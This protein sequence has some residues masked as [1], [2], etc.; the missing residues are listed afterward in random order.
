MWLLIGIIGMLVGAIV[1]NLVPANYRGGII[2][3]MVV[4]VCA[5]LFGAVMAQRVGILTQS[6]GGF[7]GIFCAVIVLVAYRAIS[8]PIDR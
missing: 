4:G 7:A 5:A 2:G 8:K 1:F 6:S 3:T